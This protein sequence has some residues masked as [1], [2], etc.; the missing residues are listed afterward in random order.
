M[1]WNM[2]D[3]EFH[4]V[5]RLPGPGRYSY[6]VKKVADWEDIWSL[7]NAD[8]YVLARDPD[9]TELVPVWPHPRLAEACARGEWEN[10]EPVAIPLETWT[11]RWIPGMEK[12]GRKVAVFPTPEDKGVV[13]TP[14]QL[15]DDLHAECKRYE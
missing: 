4:S 5:V 2:S 12:D 10:C 15:L 14:R 1:S 13:A 3:D 11:A 6:F 7:R 8:G 9:G